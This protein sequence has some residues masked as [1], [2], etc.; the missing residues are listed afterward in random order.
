M[1]AGLIGYVILLPVLG[2]LVV[3]FLFL[4]LLSKLLAFRRWGT[5]LV[6]SA[7]AAGIS[8]LVFGV[9]LK[10]QFPKGLINL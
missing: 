6:V 2:Y 5:I 4:V 10:C 1:V 9:W 8:Y 7:L 3:T